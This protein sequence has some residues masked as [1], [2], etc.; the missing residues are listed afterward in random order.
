MTG[1]LDSQGCCSAFCFKWPYNDWKG[2]FGG[3]KYRRLAKAIRAIYS[4]LYLDLPKPTF[5]R[6]PINSILG[7]IIRTYKK[8][9]FGRLRYVQGFHFL[10]DSGFWLVGINVEGLNHYM[11]GAVHQLQGWIRLG[12]KV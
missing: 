6:V 10:A 9:G 12:F 3:A 1:F 4:D 2:F 7:C 8:V 11:S 5:N